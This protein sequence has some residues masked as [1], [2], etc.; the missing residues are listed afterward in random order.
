MKSSL[1]IAARFVE[2]A[3][4]KAPS[5]ESLAERIQRLQSEARSLARSHIS[6][7][8]SALADVEALAA[9]ISEGGD[10]Y[11]PGV[12][13]LTRRLAEDCATRAK[14]LEVIVGRARA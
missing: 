3:S 1:S 11:P 6:G 13:D 7:L 14:T 9:E 10:A 2:T 8:V 5:P 4:A 12:R